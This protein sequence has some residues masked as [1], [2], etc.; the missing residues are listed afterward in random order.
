M[1]KILITGALGFVGNYLLSEF[2]NDKNYQVFGTY[3]NDEHLKNSKFTSSVIFEKIN[4]INSESV[5]NLLEKIKPDGIFNLAAF[6]S[7]KESFE[8]PWAVFE[9]NLKSELNIL[10]GLRKNKLLDTKT[11]LVSSSEIYGY[12]NP[13][14]LPI[15]ENAPIAPINPYAISK[16]TCDFLGYQYFVSYKM[17]IVRARPFNHIGPGQTEG[18]VIS[19]FAK[20]IAMIEK[21]L[22]EPIIKVGNLETKRDFTDVRDMALAYKLLFEMGKAGEVYNLGAGVSYKISDILNLLLSFSKKEISIVID[23]NK[24]RPTDMKDNVCDNSKFTSLTNWKIKI[25]IEKTLEETL[26]YWRNLV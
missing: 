9:N 25:S 22:I 15:N 14:Y 16:A 11:I 26:D 2:L 17:P 20:Q 6:S 19:D 7:V 10:E 3:L 5:F 4:L 18:F 23:S 21:G 24:L 13:K 8:N 1:K 12:I